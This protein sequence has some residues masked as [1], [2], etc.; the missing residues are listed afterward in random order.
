MP[1]LGGT[2][3]ITAVL[4][5]CRRDLR[6]H[7]HLHCVVTGGAL[8][9]DRARWVPSPDGFLFPVQVM[10][11][12]FRGK[13]MAAF[14]KAWRD[15]QVRL[16]DDDPLTFARLRARLFDKAWVVYSK[17]PFAGPEQV[18]ACLGRYTHRVGISN[19]R[20]DDVT[21]TAV[22]IR[23][24]D[25]KTDTMPPPT[26]SSAASSCT[27]CPAASDGVGVHPHEARRRGAPARSACAA[28]A[29]AGERVGPADARAWHPPGR[30]S[31]VGRAGAHPGRLRAG[32]RHRE[33]ATVVWRGGVSV[34]RPSVRARTRPVQAPVATVDEIATGDRGE[35]PRRSA[36]MRSP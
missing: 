14:E 7:P 6:Y 5:T 33:G 16:D 15:G 4:H 13:F 20:I 21:P 31:V 36:P 26:S 19:H 23:T 22:R 8:S 30:L 9:E 3:G 18:F 32:V 17:R 34:G 29:A 35:L 27:S 24:R 2:L 28:G 25:G 11:K 1:G 12:L 10:S